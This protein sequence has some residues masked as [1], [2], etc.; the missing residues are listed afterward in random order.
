MALTVDLATIQANCTRRSLFL[1][2]PS[3][4]SL[5]VSLASSSLALRWQVHYMKRHFHLVYDNHR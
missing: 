3:P 1:P 2:S 4:P 5:G